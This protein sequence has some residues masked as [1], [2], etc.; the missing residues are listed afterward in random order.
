MFLFLGMFWLLQDV[1]CCNVTTVSFQG[2]CVY[3][4]IWELHILSRFV[5]LFFFLP[6]VR[7]AI[8]PA[9]PLP[10]TLQMSYNVILLIIAR[11]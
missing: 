8:A 3:K 6:S 9:S 1:E 2:L 5:W 10:E 4:Y 11:S 7:T